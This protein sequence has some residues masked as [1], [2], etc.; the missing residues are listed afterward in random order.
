MIFHPTDLIPHRPPF[1]FVD[2]I[3]ALD[4]ERSATAIWTPQATWDVFGGHFPGHPILPGV[5]QVEAIAQVAGCA[6]AAG[7]VS[8]GE[9][10]GI[11][12]FGK[13][14]QVKFR[15]PVYPGDRC[16]I[17][18]EITEMSDIAIEATGTVKVGGKVS[19]SATI[20]CVQ[21]DPG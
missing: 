7:P 13:I 20:M 16:E 17:A 8:R 10:A 11:A 21:A 14:S 18:V 12:L 15:R 5:L 19:C 4:P 1:L 6:A 3:V 2:E 9:D